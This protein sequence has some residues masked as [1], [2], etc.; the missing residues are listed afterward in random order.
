MKALKETQIIRINTLTRYKT[1]PSY[2]VKAIELLKE[3]KD[4]QAHI[5]AD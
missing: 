2:I 3:Y 5:L 1:T 4:K